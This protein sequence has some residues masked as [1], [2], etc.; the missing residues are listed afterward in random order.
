MVDTRKTYLEVT[1]TQMMSFGGCVKS[2]GNYDD[3]ERNFRDETKEMRIGKKRGDS[4]IRLSTH[5]QNA[6]TRVKTQK[7]EKRE[8]KKN[9]IAVA[10]RVIGTAK[11]SNKFAVSA[12]SQ[13]S[14]FV[15]K[16]AHFL[17]ITCI[18][19]F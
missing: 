12:S 13:P 18:Y 2:N 17:N 6:F 7:R 14:D 1:K 4:H 10:E 16:S 15:S 19:L 3:L 5:R 11:L 8:E 9:A